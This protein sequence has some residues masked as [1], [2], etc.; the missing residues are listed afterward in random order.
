MIHDTFTGNKELVERLVI[1]FLTERTKKDWIPAGLDESR[2]FNLQG[3]EIR[4]GNPSL[5]HLEDCIKGILTGKT[6]V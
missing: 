1:V 3:E 6:R 4:R 2:I 5:E